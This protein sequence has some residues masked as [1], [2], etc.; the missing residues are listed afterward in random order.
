MEYVVASFNNCTFNKV[1]EFIMF[2]DQLL[3][4]TQCGLVLIEQ[5]LCELMTNTSSSSSS[6][7]LLKFVGEVDRDNI[8]EELLQMS[9]LDN[10]D[11]TVL[12]NLFDDHVNWEKFREVTGAMDRHWFKMRVNLLSILVKIIKLGFKRE[13]SEKDGGEMVEELERDIKLFEEYCQTWKMLE[14]RGEERKMVD[15]H[16]YG[17]YPPVYAKSFEM[18]CPVYI[19]EMLRPVVKLLKEKILI[20]GEPGGQPVGTMKYVKELK[21]LVDKQSGKLLKIVEGN[22]KGFEEDPKV[23]RMEGIVKEGHFCMEHFSVMRIFLGV[24]ISVGKGVIEGKEKT[25]GKQKSKASLMGIVNEVGRKFG[26]L[27]M[28]WG[29]FL[30]FFRKLPLPVWGEGGSV[31]GEGFESEFICEIVPNMHGIMQGNCRRSH[32]MQVEG[33][34]KVAGDMKEYMDSFKE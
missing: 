5:R 31:L 10:R 9:C 29:E 30:E 17:V 6:D 15:T 23:M 26:R 4:S 21:E 11:M 28:V 32:V 2:R 13:I 18:G 19:L 14:A 22:L 16:F 8:L 12:E 20:G 1:N 25:K 27:E 3:H 33:F 7:L 34:V 24:A